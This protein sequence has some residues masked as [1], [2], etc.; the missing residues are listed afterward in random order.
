MTIDEVLEPQGSEK[1]IETSPNP[2]N[3]HQYQQYPPMLYMHHT[4]PT[5]TWHREKFQT[6]P[7][8]FSVA[9]LKPYL[10][11]SVSIS[12]RAVAMAQ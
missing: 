6:V 2:P 3:A 5:S 1:G 7:S 11:I 8:L 12:S 10:G 4:Q 9:R